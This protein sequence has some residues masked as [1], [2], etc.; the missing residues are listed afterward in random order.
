MTIDARPELLRM[1]AVDKTFGQ[2]VVALRGM[3]LT[4]REG[5]FISLLG[6]SGCGKSTALRLIADLIHPTSGSIASIAL[7]LKSPINSSTPG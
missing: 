1:T 2:S 4:V 5:D 6:P 7:A 3:A